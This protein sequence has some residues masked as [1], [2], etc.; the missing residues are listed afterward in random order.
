MERVTRKVQVTGGSTYIISLPPEWI[1]RNNIGKGSEVSVIDQGSDLV[2]TAP[3]NSE[4]EIT[5]KITLP[6]SYTGKPLQRLLTSTY[7]SGFDTLVVVSKDKMTAEMRDDIKRFAKVVMGIEVIEETSRSIVLQNV[8]N[9]ST[10]PLQK[11]IRRMSLNVSTMIED[12]IKAI[13]DEDDDLV[14]NIILRDDEVDRYQWYIYREVKIRC[15]DDRSNVYILVLSRILERIAD[16]A[17]NICQ[18]IKNRKGIKGKEK[19]VENLAYSKDVYNQAME[20]FY[21]KNF[22]EID[23]I[24][25]RKSEITSRKYELLKILSYDSVLSSVAEEISRIG[26]YGTDIA[27]LAMDLIMSDKDEFSV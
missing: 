8:L 14:E 11:A 25:N 5:K 13:Q 2:V 10:F 18:A 17:V 27:E 6:G 15:R 4:P 26:L 1:K 20:T 9:A 7:I 12:T 22:G 24:I 21:S 19:M 3:E 23:G 16:H